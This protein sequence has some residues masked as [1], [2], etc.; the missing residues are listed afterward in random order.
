MQRPQ[1][2]RH[3]QP[4][5]STDKVIP[6]IPYLVD[7]DVLEKLPEEY[8]E[9]IKSLMGSFIFIDF[10][11]LQLAKVEENLRNINPMTHS[12]EDYTNLSKDMRLLWRF[13][14]DLLHYAEE[15][16]PQ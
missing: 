16:K 14:T 15:F 2:I 6:Q 10:C 8:R 11:K 5:P 1:Q 4:P 3:Q 7:R 12:V 13:W 9:F